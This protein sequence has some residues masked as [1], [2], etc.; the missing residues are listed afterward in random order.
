MIFTTLTQLSIGMT[1]CFTLQAYLLGDSGGHLV[2]GLS[3][4]NPVLL[5][6]LFIAAATCVSFLHLGQPAN[7]PNA[8]NN[9]SGSWLS[10]EILAL[11][12]Y[13][14]CLLAT[15]LMGWQFGDIAYLAFARLLCCMAGLALLWMMIR[16]YT[17]PTVPAWNNWYTP[18][19]F[20]STTLCLGLLTLL[21]FDYSGIIIIEGRQINK[22]LMLL[23][24][25]LG[26]ELVTGYI[27]QSRLEKMDTG[28][29]G[30][31]FEKGIF[32]KVFMLRMGALSIAF[33][34]LAGMTLNP[35][36][37]AGTTLF[38][39]LFSLAALVFAQELIGRLLFY[40]S[41]FRLGV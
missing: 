1:L 7:A 25:V 9:L 17:I 12:I 39:F 15:L 19:S 23:T 21:A 29:A 8:L 2:S 4:V 6:L 35:A 16:I 33:L 18:L 28:I 40:S 13:S 37:L 32:H 24:L 26:V 11:G 14:A 31:S 5:A 30:L 3:L 20:V 41:Y 10:R 27:H 34:A 22:L 38:S 36:S